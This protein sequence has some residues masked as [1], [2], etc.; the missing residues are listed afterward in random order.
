MNLIKI[1]ETPK[2]IIYKNNSSNYF[3]AKKGFE[4]C[5]GCCFYLKPECFLKSDSF[6]EECY[7]ENIIYKKIS[8]IE[9]LILLNEPL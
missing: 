5:Q 1:K 3:L 2:G 8:E 4:E 7:R 6:N 9:A